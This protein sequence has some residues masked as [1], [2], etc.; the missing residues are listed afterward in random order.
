MVAALQLVVDP[1][2]SEAL[3][4]AYEM[5]VR[6]VVDDRKAREA[7]KRLGVQVTGTVG[8]LLKAKQELLIPSIRPILDDLDQHGF[9]LSPALRQEALR[10]AGE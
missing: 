8:L 7:A 6:L 10:L 9:H 2:E 3:C 5:G 1:G 4:L